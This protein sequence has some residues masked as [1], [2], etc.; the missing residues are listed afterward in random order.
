MLCILR[1]MF[2]P[3]LFMSYTLLHFTLLASATLSAGIPEPGVVFYGH[4]TRSP[5]NTAYVPAGVTWSLSGNA[6][7][8][9]V[10]QTTVV[11]VNGATFY[12]TRIPFETRQLADH[13]PLP[14]TP[15][16]LSLPAAA[17]TYTRSATVDGRPAI[18]P[19]GTGSFSYGTA[20]QGLIERLDLVVGETFAEWSQ[21]LFGHA[22]DPNG[23]ED[24]DGQT[25]MQ[26]Y[27]A[28]TDPKN[29]NSRF[30][31]TSLTPAAGG[32]I[33][34]TW[35]S[36]SGK[37]YTVE[38]TT[39]FQTWTPLQSNILG[40]GG[41]LSFTDSNPGGSLKLFYRVNTSGGP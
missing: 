2:L 24:G 21:R 31:V 28:G 27:L 5:L 32:G 39:D 13:T 1:A 29:P 3:A 10:S 8:L 26:E 18:L 38:R 36:T 7:T 17:T 22:V 11:S 25:N 20:T 19:A 12:L 40:T 4:V 16:T 41:T 33:T 30:F 35:D 15:N 37:T 34:F 9:A 6:E 23:D 14:A